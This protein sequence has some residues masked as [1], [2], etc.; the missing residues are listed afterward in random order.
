MGWAT[1]PC[2]RPVDMPRTF[3]LQMGVDGVPTD[4]DEEMFTTAD[5]FVD[6]QPGQVD[7]GVPRNPH[8]TRGQYVTLECVT[9]RVGRAPDGVA[10][11]H[12]RL[13]TGSR[14]ASARTPP[15]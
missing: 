10:F 14:G 4:P 15:P 7:G 6:L 9:Q 11:G 3:H 13:A 2:V 12:V 1:P 8:I 5:D